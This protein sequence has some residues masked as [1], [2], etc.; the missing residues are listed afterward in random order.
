MGGS[1]RAS[2]SLYALG[3][4]TATGTSPRT[5][6]FRA[7][8]RSPHTPPRT[9]PTTPPTTTHAYL[10]TADWGYGTVSKGTST[11]R[12]KAGGGGMVAQVALDV[13]LAA[14]PLSQTGPIHTLYAHP[15]P[16]APGP[17]RVRRWVET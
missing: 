7:H 6:P 2:L 11:W 13:P 15:V 14:Y 3:I 16:H 1:Q 17:Q 9:A 12:A 5:K 10:S 8:R 4:R